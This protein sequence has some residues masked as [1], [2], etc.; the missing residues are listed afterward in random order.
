METAQIKAMIEGLLFSWSDPLSIKDLSKVIGVDEKRLGI[1]LQEMTEEFD[2]QQRGIQ[3][4]KMNDHYQL[5]SRP[6]HFEMIQQLI[7]PKQNKG[8][9]QAALET[10]AIIA[11]RQPV[12]KGEIERIRGVKCDKALATLM[13]RDLIEEK[14]RL[15]KTG[16]PI[17]YGTTLFFLKTFGLGALEELPPMTDFQLASEEEGEIRDLLFNKSDLLP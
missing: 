6:E 7:E 8:L 11:Y 10:L 13:E 3:I 16:R 1:L 14:G 5:S 15:E 4:I 17:L 12:P 9:T 2:Q